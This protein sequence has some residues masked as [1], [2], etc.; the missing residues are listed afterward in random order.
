MFPLFD[1]FNG[2]SLPPP[3]RTIHLCLSL[4]AIWEIMLSPRHLFLSHS[5]LNQMYL[6][7][8]YSSQSPL[9]H[10]LHCDSNRGIRLLT[11]W[12]FLSQSCYYQIYLTLAPLVVPVSVVLLTEESNS[13]RAARFCL[14]CAINRGIWLSPC[15]SFLSQSWFCQMYFFCH[16][17]L[18]ELHPFLQIIDILSVSFLVYL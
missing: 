14:S 7:P 10:T 5:C 9:W 1:F 16:L 6:S 13:G 11:K 3:P 2:A 18:A 4:A 8:G 12:S 15:C 17:G